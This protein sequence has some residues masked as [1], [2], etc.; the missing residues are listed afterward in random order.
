MN[1][2]EQIDNCIRASQWVRSANIEEIMA[3]AKQTI[4][5][6]EQDRRVLRWALLQCRDALH[7]GPNETHYPTLLSIIETAESMTEP[8]ND[9]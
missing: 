1:I 8:A 7:A 2:T 6:L 9:R 4:E 3:E 5:K